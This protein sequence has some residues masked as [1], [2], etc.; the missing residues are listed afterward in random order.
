MES[1]GPAVRKG[2]NRIRIEFDPV[3]AKAAYRARL[4]WATVTDD[5]LGGWT[6]ADP[7]THTADFSYQVRVVDEA[8]NVGGTDSQAIDIDTPTVTTVGVSDGV[9]SDADAATSFTVTVGFDQPMS[10][11]TDPTL[12]FAPAVAST[13]GAVVSDGWTDAFTYWA[14]YTVADAGVDVNAVTIDVTGAV[15]A[16]G[17]LQ[18]NYAPLVEFEIDTLNPVATVTVSDTFVDSTNTSFSVMV[19]FSEPMNPLFVPTVTLA[20]NPIPPHLSGPAGSWNLGNT[21]YTATYAVIDLGVDFGYVSIDVS[22]AR[23]VAGND[24]A[25]YTPIGGPGDF[26]LD[27]YHIYGD[28]YANNLNGNSY[29]DWIEG[30]NSVDTLNGGGGNDHLDGG[31]WGD[32]MVGGAGD[33]TYIVDN[34]ADKTIEALAGTSGGTDIVESLVNFTL[35]A[36]VE[37]LTLMGTGNING[38]G[39]ELANVI[40]GNTGANSLM[41]MAGHDTLYGGDGPDIL[42]GGAGNDHLYGEA[43]DDTFVFDT[44]PNAT[45]NVD[46]IYGFNANGDKI[47]LIKGAFLGVNAGTPLAAA[48]FNTSDLAIDA[49]DRIIFNKTTGQLFHD[50]DGSAGVYSQ[51]HFATIDLAS[52]V[53]TVDQVTNADFFVTLV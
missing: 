7:D 36:N 47:K 30:G 44:A 40:T 14:S 43:G 26:Y 51:I 1:A 46:T 9:I 6:Y 3:D 50:A 15:G 31:Q 17:L 18:D 2:R 23:D 29:P 34:T 12:V 8:G 27:T 4:S 37:H 25:D 22:G 10:A 38:K 42:T 35:L 53:G 21:V 16:N 5:G 11:A 41:G 19:A 39:Q 49:S 24:Q 33:D 32:S 52:L 45:S 28:V 13:L 20:P 48:A